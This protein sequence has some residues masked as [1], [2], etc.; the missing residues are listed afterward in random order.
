MNVH[1]K[2]IKMAQIITHGTT[3]VCYLT[4]TG[5]HCNSTSAAA[6]ALHIGVNVNGCQRILTALCTSLGILTFN[7]ART[8][9][10]QSIVKAGTKRWGSHNHD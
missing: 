5:R 10:K 3:R 9:E 7:D 2:Y 8:K 6:A 4:G 1:Y